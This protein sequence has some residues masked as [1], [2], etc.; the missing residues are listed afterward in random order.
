M[1]ALAELDLRLCELCEQKEEDAWTV[2]FYLHSNE[3]APPSRRLP[4]S[5]LLFCMLFDPQAGKLEYLG[6]I[7]TG[8]SV[9]ICAICFIRIHGLCEKL[10]DMECSFFV[11][12][13]ENG[14]TRIRRFQKS[15]SEV[16]LWPSKCNPVMNAL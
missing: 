9:A 12:K 3:T 10:R 1:D 15:V 2:S 7:L 5:V 6:S 16:R 11:M 8:K 13:S 14:A 4:S